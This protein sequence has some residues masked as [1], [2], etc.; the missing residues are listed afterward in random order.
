[1]EVFYFTNKIGKKIF[2]VY[3]NPITLRNSK[4]GIVI[5]NPVGQEYIRCYYAI[6]E[7]AKRLSEKGFHVLRFDYYGT[8]E[9]D[10][11]AEDL[12]FDG[13]V[14]DIENAIREIKVGTQVDNIYLI[15]LRLGAALAL[16]ASTDTRV[17]AIVM[18]S[19]IL[20]GESYLKELKNINSFYNHNWLNGTIEK[21]LQNKDNSFESLGFLVS[22]SLHRDIINIDLFKEKLDKNIKML[23]LDTTNSDAKKFYKWFLDTSYHI[24]A[25]S[26]QNERFWLKN[27]NEMEKSLI[28]IKDIDS[29][30]SW[31]N[32]IQK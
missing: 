9:S 6:L 12:S 32:K 5:C 13:M 8:G 14:G 18:W 16:K 15:G 1:M 31:I 22:K 24:T 25:M 10:G 2:G 27:E 7:L 26:I 23:M 21:Q 30:I 4:I 29:I 28:P 11:G 3:H 20:N 19:P 17:N